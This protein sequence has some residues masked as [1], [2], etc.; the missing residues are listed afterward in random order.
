MLTATHFL[1][2]KTP[3][4]LCKNLACGSFRFHSRFSP[5]LGEYEGWRCSRCNK[6]IVDD[7][8]AE[9]L[10]H[11]SFELLAAMEEA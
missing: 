11:E 3:D 7:A 4:N 9:A 8:L 6:L 5:H 1:T 2:V 10:L